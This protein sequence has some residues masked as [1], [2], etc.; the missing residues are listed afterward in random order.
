MTLR[1]LY[2]YTKE[3]YLA[4]DTIRVTFLRDGKARIVP[5]VLGGR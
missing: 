1:D 2:F 4:G 5:L 3:N